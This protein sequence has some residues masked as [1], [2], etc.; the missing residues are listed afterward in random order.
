MANN[1]VFMF[2]TD[3]LTTTNNGYYTDADLQ[4]QVNKDAMLKGAI[5][6]KVTNQ[7]AYNTFL[8]IASGVA[9]GLCS[10]IAS[11]STNDLGADTTAVQWAS[12]FTNLAT[13]S[14]VSDN[15]V[16]LTGAKTISGVKTFSSQIVSTVA[17]GTAP[18]SVTSTTLVS[19]LNADKLDGQDG[20]YYQNASNINA[21]T[22]AKARLP[23]LEKGDVGLGNVDNVQQYSASNPPP[24]PVTQSDITRVEGK[25][26]A[27]KITAVTETADSINVTLTEV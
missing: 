6:G 25:I 16:P 22:L 7:F 17:T 21:G 5:Y 11:E 26:G 13:K 9:Y 2:G 10:L 8:R 12:A 27:Y 23:Q 1:K 20:S 14:F 24:Y 19:N 15:Y 4:Q 18:F 3:T